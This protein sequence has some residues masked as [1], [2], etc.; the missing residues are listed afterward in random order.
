[1]PVVDQNGAVIGIVSLID[2]IA[3]RLP[4]A[5]VIFAKY[6]RQEPGIGHGRLLLYDSFLIPKHRVSIKA[7]SNKSRHC[8]CIE[9]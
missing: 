7:I 1:M 2:L 9:R 4:C 6:L 8:H 5:R 3:S